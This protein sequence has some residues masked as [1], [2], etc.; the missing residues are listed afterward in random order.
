MSTAW[1][2]LVTAWAA[3]LLATGAAVL[4]AR[5][6]GFMAPSNP[7]VPQ[8][9]EPAALGGGA[10]LFVGLSAGLWAAGSLAFA[11]A[12]IPALLLGLFDDLRPL[13]PLVKFLLQCAVA[14]LGMAMVLADSASVAGFPW[15]FVGGTLLAVV[16]MN[17]INFLDVSDGYAGLVS[18]ISFAGLAWL[19]DSAAAAAACGA[20][21]GFLFWNWPPARIYMGDAGGQVLGLAGALLVLSQVQ[22]GRAGAWTGLA[23]FGV[24]LFEIVLV[25]AVRLRRRVPFWQGSPDHSALRLQ[26]RGFTRQAAA[27]CAAAV[28]LVLVVAAVAAAASA[29]AS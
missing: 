7:I 22:P 11:A 20:C 27:L 17:A 13:R 5:R 14:A 16:L 15:L 28:Q 23:C 25:V 9:R 2:A 18:A 24:A 3:A 12:L 10:A 6:I 21:I 19:G 4:L 8:K 29:E 1:L 26:A